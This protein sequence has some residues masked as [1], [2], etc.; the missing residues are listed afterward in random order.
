M[1]HIEVP[2][3]IGDRVTNW[4]DARY[5][6]EVKRLL[7]D[8]GGWRVSIQDDVDSWLPAESLT[9]V[10]PVIEWRRKDCVN[11][12]AA[13]MWTAR[14]DGQL[15]YG[16]SVVGTFSDPRAVAEDTQRLWNERAK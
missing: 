6:W 4:S 11:L 16:V 1:K 3:V 2:F 10:E 12:W 14:D 15:V 8:A 7:L 9:L 5:V 13:G